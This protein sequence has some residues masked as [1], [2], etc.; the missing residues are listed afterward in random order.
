MVAE[1]IEKGVDGATG[2]ETPCRL[3]IAD[4]Q[5]HILEALRLLLRPEGSERGWWL[6]NDAVEVALEPSLHYRL[7][8]GR[9]IQQIV[10]RGQLRLAEG[11]RLRWKLSAAG[12]VE[13][14]VDGGDGAA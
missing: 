14:R 3:L 1:G 6:R 13:G 5:P 7:G 12:S 4:D 9:R 8:Q 11:A 2:T 10:L